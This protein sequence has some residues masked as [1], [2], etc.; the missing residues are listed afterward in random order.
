MW[1]SYGVWTFFLRISFVL[2]VDL[3]EYNILI[4]YTTLGFHIYMNLNPMIC[5]ILIKPEINECRIEDVIH[6]NS[7][8]N[9]YI[10]E[11][12]AICGELDTTVRV[13]YPKKTQ[14][15][16]TCKPYDFVVSF[17]AHNTPADKYRQHSVKQ[18]HLEN[19]PTLL[20]IQIYEDSFIA[21]S[22]TM[23]V[24]GKE[25]NIGEKQTMVR[26]R[27]T[28]DIRQYEKDTLGEQTREY[29]VMSGKL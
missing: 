16:E 25:S 24:D 21:K 9:V 4:D 29:I 26:F 11:Q 18:L 10:E 28:V 13:K 17:D 3:E 1:I 20:Q 12:T 22:D 19:T 8:E 6:G 2:E 23:S 15:K 5:T 27:D 7:T 14:L